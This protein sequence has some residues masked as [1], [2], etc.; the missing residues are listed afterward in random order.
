VI[1]PAG[2]AAGASGGL[3]GAL[4]P[5][6]PEHW[7]DKKAFQLESLLAAEGFWADVAAAGGTDPGYA[8]T[9]RLQP[10]ADAA[11][12]TLARARAEGAAALW[13]GRALWE[14]VAQDAALKFKEVCGLQAEAWSGAEV[15][16][17][18]M[19]L[20]E[21]GFPMLVLA[22]RG[23]AQAGLLELAAQMRARGAQVV[24]AAP[25]GTPGVGLPIVATGHADLDPISL[26]QSF[27]LGVEAL[28]RARGLQPD[29]PR[30]LN[31]VTRTR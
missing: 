13:Q 8:R 3:V 12:V 15:Q 17:G 10:L 4:A 27:Y 16:H 29:E 14:V 31:K 22:P 7:N 11:A 23:P 9:G 19:A 28:A 18:P 2:V 21:A 24:L 20:V 30:H 25:A 26:L 5:H 1:D 6:V